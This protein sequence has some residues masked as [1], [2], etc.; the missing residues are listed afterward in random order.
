MDNKRQNMVYLI[1]GQTGSGKTTTVKHIIQKL[2]M[3]FSKAVIFDE[4]DSDVWHNMATNDRPEWASEKVPIVDENQLLRLRSGVVRLIQ[5]EAKASHYWQVFNQLR[6][7]II[8][9]EDSR[10]MIKPDGELHPDLI[11][12]ILNCKQKNIELIFVFHA[13]LEIN[14]DLVHRIRILILHHTGE[15][16]V[17]YRFRNFRV[18]QGFEKL[19]KH[20]ALKFPFEKVVIPLNVPLK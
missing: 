9:I 15:N 18:L 11:S 1:A 7:T 14:P 3:N 6:N 4:F 17:P 12:L 5:T 13:L 8:V 20:D 2:R 19:K 16:R 10:R